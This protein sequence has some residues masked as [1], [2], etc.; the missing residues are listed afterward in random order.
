MDNRI[1]HGEVR[2]NVKVNE[3]VERVVM[4]AK[5]LDISKCYLDQK[6]ARCLQIQEGVLIVRLE[7]DIIEP[8]AHMLSIKYRGKLKEGT[9]GFSIDSVVDESKLR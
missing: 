8:G 1:F 9:S 5:D 7:K 2:I 6:L 4:H 3:H